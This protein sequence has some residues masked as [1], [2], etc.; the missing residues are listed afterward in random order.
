MRC[1]ERRAALPLCPGVRMRH[2]GVAVVCL[3]L[4]YLPV[5]VVSLLTGIFSG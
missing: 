2:D 1:Y 4:C 5:V 3:P